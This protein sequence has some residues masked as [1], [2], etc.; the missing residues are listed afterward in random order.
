[1]HFLNNIVILNYSA[2]ATQN[3]SRI[4]VK[5]NMVMVIKNL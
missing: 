4:E 5:P 2:D 3:M 1:M